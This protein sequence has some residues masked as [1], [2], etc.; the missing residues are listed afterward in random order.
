MRKGKSVFCKD[1]APD[2]STMLQWVT[3]CLHGRYKLQSLGYKK[4][5]DTKLESVGREELE[6][7]M[8]KTY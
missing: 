5:K 1:T 3:P 6:V 2:R 8:S 4:N 7:N